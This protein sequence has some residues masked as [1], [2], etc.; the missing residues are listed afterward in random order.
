MSKTFHNDDFEDE[1]D[2]DEYGIISNPG[3]FEGEPSWV[4]QLWDRALGGF[5]DET[6]HDGTMAIDAFKLDANLATL[7]GLDASPDHYICLWSDDN[8]FV[9]HM[10]MT[11]DQLFACEG[12]PVEDEGFLEYMENDNHIDLGGE[13]GY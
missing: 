12:M 13:S 2:T 4:T 8:G 1:F 3:K 6:V 11:Q 5:A 9:N 10:L 7:T